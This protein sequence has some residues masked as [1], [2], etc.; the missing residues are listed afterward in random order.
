M[1]VKELKE[2]LVFIPDEYEI[3]LSS[4]EEGNSYSPLQGINA[5]EYKYSPEDR[6]IGLKNLTPKHEKL[7]YTEEDLFDW[8]GDYEIDDDEPMLYERPGVECVIFWP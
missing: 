2:I 6:E 1:N 7:G 8:N 4:D 3:V 5:S